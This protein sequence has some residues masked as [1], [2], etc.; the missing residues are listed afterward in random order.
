M[1]IKT[2]ADTFQDAFALQLL[3][4]NKF[5]LDIGCS[6][7]INK[8]NS[9]LLEENG[10]D[11]IL[12]DYGHQQIDSCRQSRKSKNVF[13]FD[14]TDGSKILEALEQSN[15]PNNIDYFSLDIDHPSFTCLQNFPLSKYRFKFMTFEHDIY[16]PRSD[17]IE[18]KE[19]TPIL[20]Q[21][22]G[23]TRFID[24][25]H[26]YGHGPYED[27]YISNEYTD[28][29]N[30]FKDQSNIYAHDALAILIESKLQII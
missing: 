14:A 7:G 17:T 18:R 28:I 22:F 1:N 13:C 21:K 20:L 30:L 23:Y 15:C 5:Y 2:Y 26:I 25:I 10:W 8:S 11:G 3:G 9:L 12:I 6:D 27:W 16:A 24:N 4:Q 19:K 29:I